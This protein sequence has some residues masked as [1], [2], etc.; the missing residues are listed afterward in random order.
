MLGLF[1]WMGVAIWPMGGHEAGDGKQLW[2]GSG[3]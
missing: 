3:T 2:R 1:V